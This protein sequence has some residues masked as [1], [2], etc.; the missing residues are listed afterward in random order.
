[1]AELVKGKWEWRVLV[2]GLGCFLLLISGCDDP[3]GNVGNGLTLPDRGDIRGTTVTLDTIFTYQLTPSTAYGP[4]IYVG[5]LEDLRSIA[6]IRFNLDTLIH[7]YPSRLKAVWCEF[8]YSQDETISS[9]GALALNASLLKL[10]WSE[11]QMPKWEDIEDF[12]KIKNLPVVHIPLTV[13][14]GKLRISIPP[15]YIPLFNPLTIV[16]YPQDWTVNQLIPI[17]SRS[18][19]GAFKPQLKAIIDS[20]DTASLDTLTLSPTDD[21]FIISSALD[22]SEILGVSSPDGLRLAIKVSLNSL[23]HSG[24]SLLIVNSARLIL[25]IRSGDDY[26]LP[27]VLGLTAGQFTDSL[28]MVHPDTAQWKGILSTPIAPD[29]ERNVV[30]LEMGRAVQEALEKGGELGAFIAS[31]S[32][33]TLFT[34]LRFLG[35]DAPDSLKPSLRVVYTKLPR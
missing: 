23:T 10:H 17:S 26:S 35:N 16:I 33:G 8:F 31:T 25:R 18:Y 24:D 2:S 20:S 22:V 21:G 32:E 28:W 27:P 30:E 34:R 7:W 11:N 1:M 9:P 3:E 19:S 14:W 29:L 15:S 5:C 13:K 6:V 12:P 4:W